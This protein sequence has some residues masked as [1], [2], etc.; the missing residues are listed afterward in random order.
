MVKLI[1]RCFCWFTAAMLV[2]LGRAPTWRFHTKL[3]KFGW[4]TFPNN[5]RMKNRTELNLGKVFYVW[6]IYHIQDFWLNLLNGYD[7]YF[8]L[9]DTASQPYKQQFLHSDW[10]KTCHLIPNHWNFTSATLNHI[11]F[12][13][14]HNIKDNE[15]NLCQAKICWQ[16]KTTTRTWKCTRCIM[17]MSYCTRQTFLSKT[18]AKSFN[19][20][21]QYQKKMGKELWRTL[22][23]D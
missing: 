15:R 9:R 16:L 8:W 14:Y 21:K 6:L 1:D 4:S 12:F 19:I 7:I 20:Q 3:Y 5:A 22:V 18:F 10:F 2:P 11:R 23:V 13:F 17:Q